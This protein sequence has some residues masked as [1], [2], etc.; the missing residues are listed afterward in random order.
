MLHCDG[1]DEGGSF[2]DNSCSSHTVT[3]HGD[4]NTEQSIKKFGTASLET[5]ITGNGYLTV[6]ASTDWRFGTGDFTIDFWFRTVSGS[7]FQS[8]MECRENDGSTGE[9]WKIQ[10]L[11]TSKI[12]FGVN[13]A[14]GA[15]FTLDSTNTFAA[16]TWHHVAVVRNGNDYDVYV[17]GS[18]EASR[19]DSDSMPITD[20]VL[21]IADTWD[22]GFEHDGNMDEIR[23][24][25]GYAAWT[26]NFT[27]PTAPYSNCS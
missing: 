21:V 12:R 15:N 1:A 14:V 17:N 26:S 25:K 7:T 24:L 27:P 16:N 13:R 10:Y 2:P 23:I 11:N 8:L 6:P 18:S 9:Y 22:G 4:A 19:S 5:S 3:S 20:S